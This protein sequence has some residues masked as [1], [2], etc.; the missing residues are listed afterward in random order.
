MRRVI[1]FVALM[2]GAA[3]DF[4]TEDERKQIVEFLGNLRESVNPPA[5]N[6]L[7][8][9]LSEL[10]TAAQTYLANCSNSGLDRN[11]LPDDVFDFGRSYDQKGPAYIDMLTY[12]ASESKNYNY[13]QNQCTGPCVTYKEMILATS[14]AV[15][16]AQEK[17]TPQ[18]VSHEQHIIIC[19]LKKNG[20][21]VEERPYK[22]GESCSECPDGFSC[23]H[24]QCF[25]NSS[26][27]TQSP[28]PTTS[29]STTLSPFLIANMVILVFCLN[30]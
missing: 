15:G 30:A 13:D 29:I 7:L 25:D 23:Y 16:C 19:L 1:Y 10:E 2:V 20:G 14:N 18:G 21:N 22:R 6:M 24:K 9:L 3:A 4:P 12:F 17:C 8:M 26:P 11:A 5:S 28:S 27:V